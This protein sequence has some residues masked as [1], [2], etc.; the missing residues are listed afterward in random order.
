MDKKP[1]MLYVKEIWSYDP[2]STIMDMLKEQ[3]SLNLTPQKKE[4]HLKRRKL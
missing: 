4:A 1:Y 2:L 3:K